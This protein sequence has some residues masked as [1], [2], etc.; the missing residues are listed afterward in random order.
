MNYIH[1]TTQEIGKFDYMISNITVVKKQEKKKET[2][3]HI[4]MS[5]N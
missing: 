3:C 5:G 4:L 1:L 2:I